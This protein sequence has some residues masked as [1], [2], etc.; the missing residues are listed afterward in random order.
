MDWGTVGITDC[1][2]LFIPGTPGS[3]FEVNGSALQGFIYQC[4]SP[5]T[6]CFNPVSYNYRSEEDSITIWEGE[7]SLAPLPGKMITDGFESDL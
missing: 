5:G 7:Y 6:G 1:N 2:N 3:F 4:L